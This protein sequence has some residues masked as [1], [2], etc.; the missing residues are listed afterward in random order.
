MMIRTCTKSQHIICGVD[1]D[2]GNESD[3]IPNDD[4][5]DIFIKKTTVRKKIEILDFV[6]WDLFRTP[7]SSSWCWQAPFNH[8]DIL[9]H[10]RNKTFQAV[11]HLI[12]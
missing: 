3:K 8:R 5:D 4:D 10:C 12:I 11:R 7:S 1:E 9:G 6:C 2:D